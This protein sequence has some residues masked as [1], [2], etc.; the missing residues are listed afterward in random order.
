MVERNNNNK[1]IQEAL[2]VEFGKRH[3]VPRNNWVM[4]SCIEILEM[5]VWSS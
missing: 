3:F 2:L 1:D 4:G 5:I